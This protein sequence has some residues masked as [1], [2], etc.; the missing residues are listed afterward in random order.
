M[1]ACCGSGQKLK[2]HS[3]KHA[4]PV[5]G[6]ECREVSASTIIHHL[7]QPWNWSEGGERFYFCDAPD[8]DVVYFSSSDRTITQDQLRAAVGQ[9]DRSASSVLCYCFGVTYGEYLSNKELKTYVVNQTKK[10]TCACN[11]RNPSGRCCL[12]DFPKDEV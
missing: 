4:C 11:V 8:C 2:G 6:Q 9:K 1:S 5:N 12:K 10:Q 7:S 3:K